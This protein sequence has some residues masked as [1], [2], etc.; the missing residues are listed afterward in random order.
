VAGLG[1]GGQRGCATCKKA[2]RK[3]GKTGTGKIKNRDNRG[4]AQGE[5]TTRST[6]KSPWKLGE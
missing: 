6:Q 5:D 1:G 3:A 2:A 4:C